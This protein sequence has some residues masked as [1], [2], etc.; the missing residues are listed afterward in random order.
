[1]NNTAPSW[2]LR[3]PS[4]RARRRWLTTQGLTVVGRQDVTVL[5]MP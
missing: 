1:M 2:L 5:R 4:I 3:I